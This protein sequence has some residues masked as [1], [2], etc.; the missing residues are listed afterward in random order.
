MP[1][2]RTYRRRTFYKRRYTP[3]R[4]TYGT[5]YRR[6]RVYR[7]RIR[8]ANWFGRKYNFKDKFLYTTLKLA[9]NNITPLPSL[10]VSIRAVGLPNWAKLHTLY[11]QYKIYKV[12]LVVQPPAGVS[13]SPYNELNDLD[14]AAV[15]TCRQY[16]AYDYTDATPPTTV[17]SMLA[18]PATKSAPWNRP[19]KMIIRPRLQ[20]LL[21][22]TGTT[23]GN[24]YEPGFGWIDV[25]DENVPHFG[26]KYLMDN[27][28]YTGTAD[29]TPFLFYR[30]IMTVYYGFKNMNK[31]GAT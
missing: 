17:A 29:N 4:R 21:Y 28:N 11:D 26:F 9:P 27:T 25:D 12:K 1:Y 20:K 10:G 24:G 14:P 16:L 5:R 23:T 22:E 7:P 2:R 30:F 31:P 18:S 15:S 8:R 19:L 6:R 3:R 13:I